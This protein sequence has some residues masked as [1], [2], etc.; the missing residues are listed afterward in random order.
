MK[1]SSAKPDYFSGYEVGASI[2]CSLLAQKVHSG[3]RVTTHQDYTSTTVFAVLT[4][5]QGA[6][7]ATWETCYGSFVQNSNQPTT[8][9]QSHMSSLPSIAGPWDEQYRCEPPNH[10]HD[11]AINICLS[12]IQQIQLCFSFPT[13]PL[14]HSA[15]AS[16]T[17][18]STDLWH[19]CY[20]HYQGIDKTIPHGGA[21]D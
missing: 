9:S 14:F 13:K 10:H 8:R 21:R 18:C 11:T 19:C 6:F 20:H 12:R 5:E 1:S 15:S 3:S 7:G 17:H 2:Q 16:Y 4:K